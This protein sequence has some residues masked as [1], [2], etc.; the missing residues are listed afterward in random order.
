[1]FLL[2][3]NMLVFVYARGLPGG[4]NL[5]KG[6]F[7]QNRLTHFAG[8]EPFPL[9]IQKKILDIQIAHLKG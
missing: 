8:F 3:Y 2:V 7:W 5:K 4:Q 6:D 1:M 9:I